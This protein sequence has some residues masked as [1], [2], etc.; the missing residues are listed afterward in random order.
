MSAVLEPARPP[1]AAPLGAGFADDPY[2]TYRAWREAGPVLWSEDFFGGAWLV[3]RHA[4]VAQVLRDPRLSAR[5]TG[6]WVMQDDDDRRELAGFQRLFARALLFLD[7]PEHGRVHELL[8]AALRPAALQRLVPCIDRT[9]DELLDAADTGRGFDFMSAVARPLPAR[10]I[11]QLLGVPGSAHAE[12]TAWSEDLSAF[13]GAL[14]PTR[15]QARR[16]Q[17]SLLAMARCVEDLLATRRHA[18]G[19][20]LIG[21]LLQA[22]ARGELHDRAELLAQCVML[23]FAGYETTRNLLGNGVQALLS[24]PAQWQRLQAEPQLIAA[25]L[26]ELLRYE[27]PVQYTGRRVATDCVL[28]GQ[29]VRRGDLVIAL[30]GAANRDPRQH[31]R[32]DELD[33]ARPPRPSLA[34]GTGPHVCIGAA[35]TML[36]GEALLRRLLER[37]PDL[38][39][40]DAAPRWSGS[41]LYRGLAALHV[42]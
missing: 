30:I 33:I 25:A 35:L 41:P 17:I 36:E 3:S 15:V 24:H 14:R 28:H 6:G 27:S 29:P 8:Y 7:E 37:R 18:P 42:G 1:G 20:D 23:L 38:R 12:I 19:D 26:R 22:E 32:P 9:I 11:A 39:L 4:E 2:P 40:R 21:L 13:L 5:R 34:F 31:D 10:V 16:A